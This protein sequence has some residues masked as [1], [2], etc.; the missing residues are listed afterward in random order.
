MKPM[1]IGSHWANFQIAVAD[2]STRLFLNTRR[3][4]SNNNN[5]DFL[6]I[7]SSKITILTSYFL[8]VTVF[9]N[10]MMDVVTPETCT[11]ILQ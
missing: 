3:H 9:S 6:F 10:L 2:G 7:V 8:A 5:F 4:I 11:K 1:F